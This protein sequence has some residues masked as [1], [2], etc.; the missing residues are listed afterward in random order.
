MIIRSISIRSKLQLTTLVI[1]LV[2]LILVISGITGFLYTRSHLTK[3]EETGAMELEEQETESET[4]PE[5]IR[6]N[7]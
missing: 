5:T 7:E 1:V 6:S 4:E 3:S 2:L